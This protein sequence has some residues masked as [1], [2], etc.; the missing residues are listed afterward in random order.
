ML[1]VVRYWS[2]FISNQSWQTRGGS[3]LQGMLQQ[4]WQ[5][6][7]GLV[8]SG[9]LGDAQVL[10]RYLYSD[11]DRRHLSDSMP[12]LCHPCCHSMTSR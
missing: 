11:V 8:P 9:S 7:S 4:H 5:G 10:G 6:A 2:Q 1:A 12:L 3:W